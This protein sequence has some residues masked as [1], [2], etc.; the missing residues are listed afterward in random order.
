M[1]GRSTFFVRRHLSK[2]KKNKTGFVASE[3]C[4]NLLQRNGEYERTYINFCHGLER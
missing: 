3:T 1:N 4:T 2:K